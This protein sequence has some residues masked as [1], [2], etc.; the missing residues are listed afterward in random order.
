MFKIVKLDTNSNFLP[1]L[2]LFSFHHLLYLT[3]LALGHHALDLVAL[4]PVVVAQIASLA[5]THR[6][7]ESILM[8][9]LE[10]KL[11]ATVLP[12]ARGAHVLGIVFPHS[13]RALRDLHDRFRRRRL[14]GTVPL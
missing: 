1:L 7:Q 3:I 4:A 2:A 14:E 8:R 13:V 12:V 11:I 6:V 10:R 5:H 9:T